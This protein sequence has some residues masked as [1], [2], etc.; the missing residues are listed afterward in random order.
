LAQI[1]TPAQQ[2]PHTREHT[3]SHWA[4]GNAKTKAHTPK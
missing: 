4:K 2:V 3:A 1:S